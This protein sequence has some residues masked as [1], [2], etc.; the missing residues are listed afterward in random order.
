MK[1]EK[2]QKIH[3][4]KR[5]KQRYGLTLGTKTYDALC[6]KLREQGDDCV[7][8]FKESNR[9][10]LFA[11]KHEGEWVPIVYDKIRH[12]IVTFLPKE[13]LEPYKDKLKV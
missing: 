12:T 2:S 9:V 7:F 11:I 8:L 1:K 6:A 10:S 3:A 13:A 5:C 4:Q